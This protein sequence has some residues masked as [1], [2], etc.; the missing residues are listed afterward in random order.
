MGGLR[1]ALGGSGS[2]GLAAR[3]GRAA[4][5]GGRRVAAVAA[6]RLG[7][8]RAVAALGRRSSAAGRR[9][10]AAARRASRSRRARSRSSAE[11]VAGAHRREPAACAASSSR[12]GA[13]R[14]ASPASPRPPVVR[15]PCAWSGARRTARPARR[16][17]LAG[18]GELRAPSPPARPPRRPG[19]AAAHHAPARP[20]ARRPARRRGPGPCACPGRSTDAERRGERAGGVGDRAAAA[21]LPV[22]EREASRTVRRYGSARSIAAARRGQRL[23]ELLG[24]AA[25]GLRHGV[26]PAT[27][28]A[29][30]LGRHRE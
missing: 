1:C 15:R 6:P 4:R 19:S 16:T 9:P 10:R 13:P 17:R 7:G 30:H 28:A 22:V 27:A 5:L 21:G 18:V 26:A 25:A 2:G 3:L 8:R 12:A 29:G 11:R 14:R 20:R 23:V 24:V